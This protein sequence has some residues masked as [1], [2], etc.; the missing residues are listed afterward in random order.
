[1][2]SQITIF[3]A[4]KKEFKSIFLEAMAEFEQRKM[5]EQKEKREKEILYTVNEVAKRLR[6]GHG[7]IKKLVAQGILRTTPD[8]LISEKSINDYLSNT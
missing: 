7:T 1:M 6:R 8:G 4:S 5:L 3:N 2:E